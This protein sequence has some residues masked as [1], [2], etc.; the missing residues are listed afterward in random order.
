M[1]IAVLPERNALPDAMRR[2]MLILGWPAAAAV[3]VLGVLL[4]RGSTASAFDRWALEASGGAIP[5]PSQQ[6]LLAQIVDF[7]GEPV[8]A[9]LL[10]SASIAICLVLGHRRSALLAILGPGLS[11][12]VTTLLKP[13]AGRTIN[14]PHLSFPSGHT[15][16]VTAMALVFAFVLA[17]RI[18]LGPRAGTAA[19]LYAAATAGAVEAWAQFGMV[20]HYPSDTFGGFCV[21]LAVVPA[22]AAGIDRVTRRG[23]TPA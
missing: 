23:G 7:A 6:W 5:Y 12:A 9:G 1:T 16:V 15:A 3:V 17:D 18:G 2:P 22:V 10:V 21:A 14:G 19:V 8:G 11:V 13:V 20:V 4:Y